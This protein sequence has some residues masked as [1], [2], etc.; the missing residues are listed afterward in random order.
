MLILKVVETG[1]RSLRQMTYLCFTQRL[2]VN[3]W[4]GRCLLQKANK[5]QDNISIQ[6]QRLIKDL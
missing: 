2:L 1:D 5:Q 6:P 3:G 4:S